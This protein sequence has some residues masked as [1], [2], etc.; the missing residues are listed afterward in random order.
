MRENLKTLSINTTV[1]ASRKRCWDTPLTKSSQEFNKLW[2][3]IVKEYTKRKLTFPEDK[4]PAL[5]GVAAEI[6]SLSSQTYLAGLW[7]D[8]LI[9][10]LLWCRDFATTPLPPPSQYRAPSWSW[11][12]IDSPIT[13]SKAILEFSDDEEA[14]VLSW[15]VAPQW[16]NSPFGR[17]LN[18]GSLKIQGSMQK[19]LIERTQ[20]QTILDLKTQIPFAF[21]QWDCLEAQHNKRWHSDRG[22]VLE[23]L[24]C[25]QILSGSGLLLRELKEGAPD[26]FQ[27]VGVYRIHESRVEDANLG[28]FRHGTVRMVV[29]V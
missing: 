2:R 23:E 3:D 29:I 19:V 14:K 7:N 15:K 24:W 5:A 20:S 16:K 18:G 8:D 21:A 4:L 25:L 9:H 28:K 1:T 17:V 11:A 13:W 22:N 26:T 27:R 12:A 6:A 10:S